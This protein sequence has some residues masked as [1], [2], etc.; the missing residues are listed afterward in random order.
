MFE[1]MIYLLNF[2][3]KK[4]NYLLYIYFFLNKKQHH[5]NELLNYLKK[6]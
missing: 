5:K 6:F 2:F 1:K 3:L 4:V